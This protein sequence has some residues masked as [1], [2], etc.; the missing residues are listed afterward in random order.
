ME[1]KADIKDFIAMMKVEM[2]GRNIDDVLN[3][4]QMPIPYS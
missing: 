1:T 3:M 4:D 2:Q